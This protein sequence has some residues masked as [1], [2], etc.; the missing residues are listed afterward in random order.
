VKEGTGGGRIKE[1]GEI[2]LE[3]KVRIEPD[4]GPVCGEKGSAGQVQGLSKGVNRLPKSSVG[5]GL[6]ESWPQKAGE[7]GAFVN[8]PSLRG[9]I[10]DKGERLLEGEN[11]LI[12]PGKNGWTEDPEE[13]HRIAPQV[14]KRSWTLPRWRRR[15]NADV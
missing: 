13:D 5:P 2:E 9:E 11:H 6:G 15:R 10:G 1:S 3:G 12:V 7:M 4:M 14:R 8:A